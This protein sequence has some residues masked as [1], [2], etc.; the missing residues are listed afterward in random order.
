MGLYNLVRGFTGTYK[1]GAYI[2]VE[3]NTGLKKTFQYNLRSSA[4]QNTF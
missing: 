3:L 1:R 4:D 2:R